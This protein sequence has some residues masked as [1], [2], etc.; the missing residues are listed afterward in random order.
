MNDMDIVADKSKVAYCGLYCGACR[1]LLSGKCPGCRD[2]VKATWCKVRS[3]CIENGIDSCAD[4]KSVGHKDCKLFNGFMAK[5]FGVIFNS[6]RG[7]CIERIKEVG[8]LTYAGEMT[9]KRM[10]T[11][12]RK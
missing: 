6:D 5:L 4:C 3:C 7:K 9:E 11:I 10:Q 8:Y 2:N 1:R 12:K